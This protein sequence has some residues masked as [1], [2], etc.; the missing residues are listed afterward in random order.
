VGDFENLFFGDDNA[1]YGYKGDVIFRYTT[2]DP[3]PVFLF[4]ASSKVRTIRTGILR[5]YNT[6]ELLVPRRVTLKSV[7]ASFGIAMLPP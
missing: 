5:I 2:D 1:I 4:L 6:I 7:L 3:L